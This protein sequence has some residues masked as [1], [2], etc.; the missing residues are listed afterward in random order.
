VQD[1]TTSVTVWDSQPTL[2]VSRAAIDTCLVTGAASRADGGW[3]WV[4]ALS[5]A[6]PSH[7]YSLLFI[8]DQADDPLIPQVLASIYLS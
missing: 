1:H 4:S 2:T 8:G 7:L 3:A 5:A 6:S